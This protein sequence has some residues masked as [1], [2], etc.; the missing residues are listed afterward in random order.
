MAGNDNSGLA[1]IVG[2][3]LVAAV[4]FGFLFY[5]GNHG[6]NLANIEPATGVKA[7]ITLHDK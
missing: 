1:L 4:I 3:L 5:N 7:S 6:N 2:G